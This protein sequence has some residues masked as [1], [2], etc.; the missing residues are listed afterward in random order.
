[1]QDL[2]RNLHT[3]IYVKRPR[4]WGGYTDVGYT[5][6]TLQPVTVNCNY[7]TRLLML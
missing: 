5:S 2:P 3:Q 6:E 1:M 4:A 7:T